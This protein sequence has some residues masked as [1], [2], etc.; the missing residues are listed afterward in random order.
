MSIDD[1]TYE[2]IAVERADE[3]VVWIALD[4]PDRNNTLDLALLTELDDALRA[5]DRDASVQGM[6]LGSTSEDLFCAGAALDELSDLDL[7]ESYRFL[8]TYN[9]TVDLLWTTGKPVVAAVT[10]TCVAGGNELVMGSDLVVAGESARFGQPEANVGS[11]AAGGGVQL[12]PLMVGMQRAKD[13]LLTSRLLS[14][15]EAEEWGLINRVVD[16]DSVD[17]RALEL[18]REIVDGK[19]PYAYRVMKAVFKR[20]YNE[21]M[22]GGAVD[23]EV[24]AAVWTNPEF[25]ER[26]A[27]FMAGEDLPPRDFVGTQ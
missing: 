16:D 17:E 18:V 6:L 27:A 25:R 4:E 1:A 11:T 21:A 24:T 22:A 8:S 9:D 12:M 3:D 14:A 2:H 19:S 13:L 7:E 10:G 15:E 26:A 23:R 5:A 20:W